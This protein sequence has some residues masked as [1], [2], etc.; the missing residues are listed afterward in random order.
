[1]L[2][3]GE[4]TSYLHER[5]VAEFEKQR[6]LDEIAAFLPTVYH[7]GVGVSVDGERYAAWMSSDGIRIAQGNA[8]RYAAR[9]ADNFV[10]SRSRTHL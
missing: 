8:A 5:V 2:R 9:R 4:N 6:S 3:V 7:G 1:M 10:G